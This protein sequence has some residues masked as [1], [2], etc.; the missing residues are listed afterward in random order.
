MGKFSENFLKPLARQALS[1]A[2]AFCAL[3][4]PAAT[5]RAKS[6]MR[7]WETVDDRNAPLIWSWADGAGLAAL[8]FS[9]RLARACSTVTVT[10]NDGETYG[11]CDQPIM[12]S[13][14]E[15]IVDVKLVQMAGGSVVAQETATLAYVSGAGGGP[16]TVRVPGRPGWKRFCEPR[17]HAFDP[18]WQD[19]ACESGYA[20][21]WPNC[22]GLGISIR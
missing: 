4:C 2:V 19:V 5:I 14:V 16:I 8:T 21:A 12:N 20:I 7:L 15:A 13:G 18:A 17:V 11:S 10:R 22:Q 6:D 1:F 9:N 3:C